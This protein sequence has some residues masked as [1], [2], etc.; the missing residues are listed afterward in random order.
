MFDYSSGEPDGHQSAD[1]RLEEKNQALKVWAPADPDA[2]MWRSLVR[3][4]D[5]LH[6]LR[7]GLLSPMGMKDVKS[8]PRSRPPYDNDVIQWRA[9]LR[10]FLSDNSKPALK[11]PLQSMTGEALADGFLF[12]REVGERRRIQLYHDY[13]ASGGIPLHRK[14]QNVLPILVAE[15]SKDKEDES[16]E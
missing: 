8:Q 14:K 10:P 11:R 1:A 13:F 12:L 9:R 4:D 7:K 5:K 3:N 16:S 15:Q 2:D 6:V